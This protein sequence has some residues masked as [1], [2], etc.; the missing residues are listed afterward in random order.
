ME[1]AD[2]VIRCIC[3]EEDAEGFQIQCEECLVWQHGVCVGYT[4]D[5][6]CPEN[7]YCEKCRPDGHPA[8]WGVKKRRRKK[9][10]GEEDD[11][12]RRRRG[13]SETRE[14]TFRARGVSARATLGDMQRRAREMLR[15]ISLLQ[16]DL[17]GREVDA[18]P[19]AEQ[20]RQDLL[21][22]AEKVT[23]MAM[24]WQKRWAS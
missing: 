1:E 19:E 22:H 9:R 12:R 24:Q 10:R 17:A 21:D 4:T 8:L 14:E 2:Y 18:S 20:R 5:K 13:R 11:N 15:W 16:V 3:K 7:Y 23:L 6:D